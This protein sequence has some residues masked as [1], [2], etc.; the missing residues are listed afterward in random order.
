MSERAL[1][2][3]D[4]SGSSSQ[5]AQKWRKWKQTFEYYTE[6]KG[7]DNTQKKT[8]QLL[9]YVGMEGEW[10]F[11]ICSRI[12][13]TLTQKDNQDPYTACIRNKLNHHFHA[14]ENIPFERHIFGQTVPN[15]WEPVDEYLVYLHQQARNC[16]FN[17]QVN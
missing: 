3:F 12:L 16:N 11:R 9:L 10:K 2:L 5:V 17:R 7:L 14:E 6:G 1:P 4:L 8:S 13:Q 15:E